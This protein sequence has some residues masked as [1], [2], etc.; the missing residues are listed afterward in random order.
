MTTKQTQG[1]A[2]TVKTTF[3][4]ATNISIDIHADK[5]IVWKL[6]TNASD[7]PRWNSTII[8]ME[9]SIEQGKKIKLK[10]TTDPSRTFN[11]TVQVLQP[12]QKM[13]WSDGMAPFFKGVRTYTLDS[14]SDGSVRFSMHEKLAGIMF[15]LAAKHIPSFDEPFEQFAADLKKEAEAIAQN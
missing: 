1:T 8:S 9:G 15:A 5:G 13:I 10:S 3:S 7:F 12:A 11:L 6:L 4:R 14:N 2:N